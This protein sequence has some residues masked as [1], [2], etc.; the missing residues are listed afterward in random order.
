MNGVVVERVIGY[1]LCSAAAEGNINELSKL[2]QEGSS[3]DVADYDLRTAMHLACSEGRL[4]T[5]KWL[6]NE[7]ANLAVKDIFGNKP[8]DDAIRYNHKEIVKLIQISNCS[9]L[10]LNSLK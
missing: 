1:K 9:G 3:L 6:I 8:I 5:V 2:K 7:G 4:S 10:S